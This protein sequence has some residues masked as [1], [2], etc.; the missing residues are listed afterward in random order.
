M[1]SSLKA[2][3]FWPSLAEEWIYERFGCGREKRETTF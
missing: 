3:E 2:V 1:H